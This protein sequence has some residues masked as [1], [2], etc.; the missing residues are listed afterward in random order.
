MR[1]AYFQRFSIIL[2]GQLETYPTIDFVQ[3]P[4]GITGGSA[5]ITGLDSM[6][7][8]QDIALVLQSG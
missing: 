5:Q 6:Q 3:N 1:S 4:D 2:D 7:E 8:A